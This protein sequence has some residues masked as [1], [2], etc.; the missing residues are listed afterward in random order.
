[1]NR[2]GDLKQKEVIN[3]SDGRRLGF[4]YDLEIN[5]EDGR[6]EALILPGGGR[7]F[8]IIGKDNEIVIPWDRVRIVGE[9]TILVDI[10]ERSLRKIFE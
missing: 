3:M 5:M 8:G 1:M 7:L 4:V 6:I 9:D 10:D 2:T